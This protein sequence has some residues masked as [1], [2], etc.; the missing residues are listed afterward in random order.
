M[1]GREQGLLS[2]MSPGALPGTGSI[3]PLSQCPGTCS[4]AS[5]SS[6]ASSF[7]LPCR[8]PWGSH[9]ALLLGT[10]REKTNPESQLLGLSKQACGNNPGTSRPRPDIPAGCYEAAWL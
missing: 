7:G 10:Q 5:P 9:T 6:P 4:T 1:L 8:A 2:C 3:P